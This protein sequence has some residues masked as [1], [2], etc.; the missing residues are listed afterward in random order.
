MYQKWL[1]SLET[2]KV[3]WKL[4]MLSGNFPGCLETFQV[5][6]KL[7]RLY[8]NFPDCLE[9]FQVVLNP[10]RS[11]GNF[12]DDLETFQVVRNFPDYVE[13]FQIMWKLSRWYGN[14]PGHLETFQII[15]KLSKLHIWKHSRHILEITV[16]QRV[17]F[18]VTRKNFPDAQKLSGWQC[19]PA[20]QVFLPLAYF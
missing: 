8:A 3:V 7:S 5:I 18:I 11:S 15:R 16:I 20:N 10:S 4:S 6:W 1:I 12:P 17:D 9:T 14:F 19:Q 13:T 2:F